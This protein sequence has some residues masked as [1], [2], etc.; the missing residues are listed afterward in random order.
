MK[1]ILTNGPP[2]SGKD[3]VFNIV[4]EQFAGRTVNVKFAYPLRK[5]A[6]KVFKIY[7]D[8]EFDDL[9]R[10]NPLIRSFMIDLS[11]NYLKPFFGKD[12]FGKIAA[13]YV[14]NYENK[15]KVNFIVSDCGFENELHSFLSEIECKRKD[16]QLW[17][18]YRPDCNFEGDSRQFVSSLNQITEVDIENFGS[19][20]EFKM[21]VKKHYRDC[22]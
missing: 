20:A 19:Y 13:Q 6:K 15:E 1:I 11:E 2:G 21:K 16:I 10:K 7:D 22:F 3:S 8:E 4:K 9:K 17:R 14:N 12:Y 18:I 5:I